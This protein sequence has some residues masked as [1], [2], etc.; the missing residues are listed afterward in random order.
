[1]IQLLGQTSS[2]KDRIKKWI[3]KNEFDEI[4]EI[5]LISTK[6]QDTIIIPTHYNC[7]CRCTN[8]NLKDVHQLAKLKPVNFYELMQAIEEVIIPWDKRQTLNTKLLVSFRGVGEPL[9]NMPLVES[10]YRGKYNFERLGYTNIAF[11][12]STMMPNEEL[13]TLQELVEKGKYPIRIIYRLASPLDDKRRILTPSSTISIDSSLAYLHQFNEHIKSNNAIKKMYQ[14]FFGSKE[15]VEIFYQIIP[16][17]NDSLFEL[18]NLQYLADRY[19]LPITFLKNHNGEEKWKEDIL[20][21]Y[22][23]MKVT[24][25]NQAS[26]APIHGEFDPH[27]YFDDDNS[28]KIIKYDSINKEQAVKKVLNNK[29]V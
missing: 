11:E 27:L 5:S 9:L 26:L 17:L 2:S 19:T 14:A 8:C 13:K 3:F 16:D 28:P 1:M 23:N 10:V 15:P 24:I 29:V 21:H 25:A 18:A 20:S 7:P 12:I 6:T 22:P 4:I